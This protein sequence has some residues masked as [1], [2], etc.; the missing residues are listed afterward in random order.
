MPMR[1]IFG[2]DPGLTGAVAVL[3]DDVFH[4]VFDIPTAGRGKKGR[5][6][7]NASELANIFR[8]Q[9]IMAHGAYVHAIVEDVHSMPGQGVST[10]FSFGKS[11]GAIEGVLG[12]L[13]IPTTFVSPA[14][15]KRSF[16][17]LGS[18]KDASRGLA[19]Q[20]V[21]SAPL[22]RKKDHGRAEAILIAK[23]GCS[24]QAWIT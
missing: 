23:W 17:L 8:A 15:W 13:R 6:V 9:I 16:G 3:H 10:T 12:A 11:C 14:V 5:Q 1:L 19:I 21:P 4:D 24:T 18:E 20:R 2:I 22:S 7:V